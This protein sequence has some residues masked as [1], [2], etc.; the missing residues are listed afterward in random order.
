[1]QNCSYTT[2]NVAYNYQNQGV[3][4]QLAVGPLHFSVSACLPAL[5]LIGFIDLLILVESVLEFLWC[6]QAKGR[7]KSTQK[8]VLPEAPN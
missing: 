1:M 3:L 7:P 4:I 5:G 6:L 2:I 8:P